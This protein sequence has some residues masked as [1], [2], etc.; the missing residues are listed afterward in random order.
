MPQFR[1]VA[2]LASRPT[3]ALT[4]AGH[5]ERVAGDVARL[6]GRE[7][8]HGVRDLDREA[9]AAERRH[10]RRAEL[11]RA[12]ELLQ[13][14]ARAL[15]VDRARGDRIHVDAV[16]RELERDVPDRKSTR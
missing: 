6:V 2:G 4:A 12:I 7:E 13:A 5:R 9:E 8:E 10:L 11:H 1:Y 3:S 16:L 15:G 14:R